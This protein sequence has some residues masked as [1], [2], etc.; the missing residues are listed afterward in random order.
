[1]DWLLES[2][3]FFTNVWGEIDRYKSL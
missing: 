1:M 3:N 2:H